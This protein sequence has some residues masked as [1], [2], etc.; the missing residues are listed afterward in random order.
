MEQIS[1]PFG[2]GGILPSGS[3]LAFS[4]LEQEHLFKDVT[5]TVFT[6]KQNFPQVLVYGIPVGIF[7]EYYYIY[8]AQSEASYPWTVEINWEFEIELFVRKTSV[9]KNK[10]YP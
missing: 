3:E 7:N 9:F 2:S 1:R 4:P 8:K 10:P 5:G 6:A